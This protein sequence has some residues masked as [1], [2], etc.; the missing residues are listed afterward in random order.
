MKLECGRVRSVG[1]HRSQASEPSCVL[2]VKGKSVDENQNLEFVKQYRERLNDIAGTAQIGQ[3]HAESA[4]CHL[5]K[6][7][8]ADIPPV[9]CERFHKTFRQ[10]DVVDNDA[11][12]WGGGCIDMAFWNLLA[13]DCPVFWSLQTK[14]T[15][16]F[17]K[18]ETSTQPIGSET[19]GADD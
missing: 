6:R 16:K 5:L 2:N 1:Q 11:P 19:S 8:A 10:N 4:L 9:Q 17:K 12:E 15:E 14:W 13:G 18:E 3:W 7:F